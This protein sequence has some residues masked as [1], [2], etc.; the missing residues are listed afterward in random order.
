MATPRLSPPLRDGMTR[1][2]AGIQER[3]RPPPTVNGRTASVMAA[4]AAP[5]RGREYETSPGYLPPELA[6]TTMNAR[7]G[8]PDAAAPQ[9]LPESSRTYLPS[10][11]ASV[12]D[13][14]GP[15]ML[16]S[17]LE[18]NVSTRTAAGRRTARGL[19]DRLDRQ[20]AHGCETAAS[21]RRRRDEPAFLRHLLPR[22]QHAAARHRVLLPRRDRIVYAKAENLNLT[23]S[24]KDRMALHILRRAYERGVLEPGGTIVEA[25]CGNTGISF[26]AIGRALG[27]PV[28]I[29]MPDWMSQERDR[30]HRQLRRR[31]RPGEPRAGRVPRAASAWPR[32]SRRAA[33]LLPAAPVRQRGQ[34]SRPTRTT[35]GPEIWWQLQ[36]GSSSPT[37]S[38]PASAPAARSWASAAICVPSGR[39]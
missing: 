5:A 6:S 15:C 22:R 14:T 35:T 18:P 10:L 31:D 2:P 30:A 20:E 11:P 28:T 29:F 9:A 16:Y 19:R 26:A 4:E 27:H 36:F 32:S 25:T 34:L 17:R 8:A 7:A 39:V 37:P 1:L 24:I 23:G 38:S 3:S 12:N 13:N 21:A 33:R